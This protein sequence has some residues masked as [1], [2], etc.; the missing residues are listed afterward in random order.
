MVDSGLNTFDKTL[1]T[2]NRWLSEI[3][4]TLHVKDRQQAYHALRGVL[5]TL[6]DRFPVDEALDLAAELPMVIR[7]VYFEEYTAANKPTKYDKDEFPRQLGDELDAGGVTNP[8][9]KVRRT[10]FAVVDRQIS[11]DESEQIQNAMPK[12]IQRMWPN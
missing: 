9:N 1:Q 5:L 6:R 4:E 3:G 2:S 8:P 7:G 11:E 12:D 10:V